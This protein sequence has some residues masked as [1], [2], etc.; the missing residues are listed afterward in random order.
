MNI[1]KLILPLFLPLIFIS[2]DNEPIDQKKGE[3]CDNIEQE[4]DLLIRLEEKE[5]SHLFKKISSV[6]EAA[7]LF[8]GNFG[9][10]VI[11]LLGVRESFKP[12]IEKADLLAIMHKNHQ[13]SSLYDEYELTMGNYKKNQRVYIFKDFYTKWGV[14]FDKKSNKKLQKYL[15]T[16]ILN[17][18]IVQEL[19]IMNYKLDS[20]I[21]EYHDT[22]RKSNLEPFRHDLI[23]STRP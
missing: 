2:C 4:L 16:K 20:I 13:L 7:I 12:L 19:I 10:T 21:F 23:E 11:S 8:S 17:D 5:T 6:T 1:N 15:A 14:F 9:D 18:I 22:I 3:N